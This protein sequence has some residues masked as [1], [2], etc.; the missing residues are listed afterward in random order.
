MRHALLKLL[1]GVIAFCLLALCFVILSL[2]LKQSSRPPLMWIPR[3]EHGEIHL[4]VLGG[5]LVGLLIC[6]VLVIFGA[7]GWYGYKERVKHAFSNWILVLSFLCALLF[8]FLVLIIASNVKPATA[9]HGFWPSLLIHIEDNPGGLFALMTGLP[10]LYGLALAIEQLWE[11]R[12]SIRSFSELIDRVALMAKVATPKNPMRIVAYTPAVGYLAQPSDEWNKFMETVTQRSKTGL[13][14]PVT[15]IVCLGDT[16]L[17]AWHK[18]FEGRITMRGKIDAHLSEAATT[19]A[20][21]LVTQLGKDRH[22]NPCDNVCRLPSS[23]LPG[24]YL[25]FTKQRAIIVV[26]LFL[27]L[28][29]ETSSLQAHNA[30][31]PTVQMIGFET[32]DRA[33][34]KD[35]ELMFQRYFE[36]RGKV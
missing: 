9:E 30:T 28:H 10:T 7:K 22:G 13:G 2:W 11:M 24:F 17:S 16:E 32:T 19:A 36:L 5:M 35:F 20:E 18:R 34:I 4:G 26:P 21:E 8:Y 25:F 27:P 31:L 12:R 14:E 33:Y 6:F 23:C 1:P 29:V 15:R 3:V